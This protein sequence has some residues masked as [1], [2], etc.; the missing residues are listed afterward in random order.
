MT[1]PRL[2]PAEPVPS[3]LSRT[4]SIASGPLL[5]PLD[6]ARRWAGGSAAAV[7]LSGSH[8]T[9]EAVWVTV[10][11]RTL[12]LSDLDVYVVVPNDAERSAAEARARGDRPGLAARLLAWGVAA[13]LEVAFLTPA[14]LARLPARPGTLEL[15]RRGV[16]VDGDAV[17]LARVPPWEARDVPPEE[18]DL[19]LENRGFELLQ[20]RAGLAAP[21]ALARLA[22]RHALLKAA[23][24]L[25]TVAVLAAGEY[26]D[27]AAGRVARAHALSQDGAPHDA[28]AGDGPCAVRRAAVARLWDAALTWRAGTAEA[29]EPRAAAAEWHEAAAAWSAV[30]WV[31]AGGAGAPEDPW[32]RALRFARRARLR[33]RVRLALRFSTRSG[34]GPGLAQRLG[35]ALRG[36]P[37]HRVNASA[38]ILLLAAAEEPPKLGG[39]AAAALERLGVVRGSDARDWEAARRAVL[40]AWDLWV[41]DGQ[42][43]AEE[44]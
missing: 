17:W 27:G 24:D 22:G 41:L 20:A 30:W 18:I 42:R 33:R 43:F 29:L 9:G 4:G 25:A 44:P 28:F 2:A 26:P 10:E 31:R 15:R 11:G 12:T 34:R 21:G 36:T 14:H 39:A 7:L 16:V 6:L 8:A 40:R 13:P 37:P 23:L 38:A 35:P 1:S 3:P 32:A 19:L 5:G